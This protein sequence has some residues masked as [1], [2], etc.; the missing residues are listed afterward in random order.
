M[1]VYSG[2]KAKIGKEITDEIV[3]FEKKL[4]WKNK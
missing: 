3:K 1:P 2:G 4:N